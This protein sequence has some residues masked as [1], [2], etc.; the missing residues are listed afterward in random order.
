MTRNLKL[1]SCGVA[2]LLALGIFAPRTEFTLDFPAPPAPSQSLP[3]PSIGPRQQS[4]N[5]FFRPFLF[6]LNDS[7]KLSGPERE[8][9]LQRQ[10][11]EVVQGLHGRIPS[12]SLIQIDGMTVVAIDAIP[13]ATVLPAD[14][15]DYSQ[16]LSETR[17]HE[18][19]VLIAE[20]W[21]YLI[22][23]DLTRE[24]YQRSPA[25]LALFP[26]LVG[27]FFGLS[28]IAHSLADWAARRLLHS[29]G[30]S[31]KAMIWL[32]F[33]CVSGLLHPSSRFLAEAAL[34]G[35]LKPVFLAVIF[36]ALAQFVSAAGRFFLDRYAGAYIST[37]IESS[38]QLRQRVETLA[39]GGRFLIS[40]LVTL[41]GIGLYLAALGVDLSKLF[42]GAG[43]A[44]LALGVVGK[45][46]LIDYFYGLNVLL[47]NQFN[48]GDFI[49]TP[50]ATGVVESFNLRTTRIRE[51]N[52]SL[53][54]VSN[55][56]LTVIKNHSR[57]FAN[58]DIRVFLSLNAEVEK[59]L[60]ILVEEIARL[61]E[62]EPDQL[63]GSPTFAGVQS[64]SVGVVQCRALVKTAPLRQ[65]SIERI[66][67]QRVLER[68]QKEQ[69]E[70]A[71]VAPLTRP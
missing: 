2:L 52:G 8:R 68:F 49:E 55:G 21:K 22:E 31:F 35:A 67:N 5:P 27:I 36:W 41:L 69:I 14:L 62:E 30:W 42:A 48:L 38:G 33:G 70:L 50:V 32:T 58:A 11:R 29:P 46:I 19:E 25:V 26:Y 15:P 47:D 6:R 56:R 20:R 17:R 3:L 24:V 64:I 40:S 10:Y 61:H 44:G 13:F 65:W 54:I 63:E 18:L 23:V 4:F 60:S 28:L 1:A 43:V 9:Q 71:S 45:D 51:Q 16:R 57:D 37:H 34:V 66:L 12:V 7:P 59:A 39:Q 53:S